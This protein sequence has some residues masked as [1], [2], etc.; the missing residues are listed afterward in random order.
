MAT[1]NRVRIDLGQLSQKNGVRTMVTTTKLI[2]RQTMLAKIQQ[3]QC[4]FNYRGVTTVV[5]IR[6]L[7]DKIMLLKN[8]KLYF[9]L[10]FK[11]MLSADLGGHFYRGG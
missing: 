7:S 1:I 5:K 11:L 2:L 6:K 9:F 3:Q 8:F 4:S 10:F